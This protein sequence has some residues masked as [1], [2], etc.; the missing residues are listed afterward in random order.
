[1]YF[2]FLDDL[3]KVEKWVG[4]WDV[5]IC[6][7]DAAFQGAETEFDQFHEFLDKLWSHWGEKGWGPKFL[8]VPGNHDLVRPKATAAVENLSAMHKKRKVASAIWERNRTANT[9]RSS[10]PVLPI[11]RRGGKSKSIAGRA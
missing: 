8:A 1:M 3:K 7:G 10:M 4:A 6:V 5:V 9:G 11:T 2:K